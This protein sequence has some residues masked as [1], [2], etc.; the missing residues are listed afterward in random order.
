MAEIQ[1]A[2]LTQACRHWIC[3]RCSAPSGGQKGISTGVEW[4]R[5]ASAE[6]NKQKSLSNALKARNTTPPVI[7]VGIYS[8][9]PIHTPTPPISM[10]GLVWARL[11]FFFD[12]RVLLFK[13]Y[14]GGAGVLLCVWKNKFLLQTPTFFYLKYIV[15]LAGAIRCW[16]SCCV[17]EMCGFGCSGI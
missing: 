13:I 11:C 9:K 2:F 7:V 15:N 10:L 4:E 8:S 3:Q 6:R 14:I 5:R 17:V 1:L 16:A 12:M